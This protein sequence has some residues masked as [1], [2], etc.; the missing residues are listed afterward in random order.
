MA[1]CNFEKYKSPQDVKSKFRHC[2]YDTRKEIEHRNKHINKSLTDENM[3]IANRDYKTVCELYDKKIKMLDNQ[4]GA[5]KRKDRVTA[6]GIEVPC[7]KGLQEDFEVEW[8]NKVGEILRGHYGA[9]NVLQSYYHFDEKHSY[10]NAETKEE[11]MSRTHG[12]FF[13]TP[14]VNGKLC[15]KE[16]TS[17]KNIMAVNNKIQEMT[18]RD[19]GIQFMDGSKKKSRKSM[20]ELKN[21][22]DVEALKLDLEAQYQAKMDKLSMDNENALKTQITSLERHYKAKEEELEREYQNK[23]DEIG[24]L[25]W[26]LRDIKDVNLQKRRLAVK[27]RYEDILQKELSQGPEF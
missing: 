8:L 13:M 7:P 9:D 10:I 25:L 18:M 20:E 14:V 17:R 26:E 1:S 24:D 5:N 12:H 4:P 2:D 23:H 15:A 16:F 3:Q 19:Y 6:V 21:E 22:S 11:C 27:T